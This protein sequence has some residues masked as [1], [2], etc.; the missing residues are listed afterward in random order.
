[1]SK[2]PTVTQAFEKGD[3]LMIK[4][5]ESKDNNKIKHAA[6]LKESKYR[7]EYKEFLSEGKKSLEMA[8]KA[9]CVKEIFT[10]EELKI[11][12]NIT[13]YIVKPDLLKKLASSV[14]PEVVVFVC[15][16]VERK[17]KKLNKVVYLDKVNDPGNVGTIIRT[18]LAFSYDAIVFS[19]G[20]CDPY[21]EKVV[22]AS[23]GAIFQLPILKG[24]LSEY[25]ESRDIIVSALSDKAVDIRELEVP[26]SFILVVG[27]EANGVSKETMKEATVITKIQID[28]IDSLNVA[29]ATGI[30]MNYLR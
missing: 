19:E 9:K 24:D 25:K 15:N 21:N 11:S 20:C 13:Q 22:A 1:M 29:I 2:L 18:A 12:E 7:K 6:S 23:K 5:I 26:K 16:I 17:P 27:N 30:L 8:L 4:Y 3:L 28:N 14:N 10:T